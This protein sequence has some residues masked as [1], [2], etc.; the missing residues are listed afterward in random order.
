VSIRDQL[1]SSSERVRHGSVL[2]HCGHFVIVNGADV[3][4]KVAAQH[5]A[6]Q[7]FL[8]AGLS[9]AARN[10]ISSLY[11]TRIWKEFVG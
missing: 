10:M 4:N 1:W 11:Y 8:P 2:V 5:W 9:I 3:A 7:L 6:N